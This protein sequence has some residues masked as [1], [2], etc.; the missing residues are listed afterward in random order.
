MRFWDPW[1]DRPE[2]QLGN[3]LSAICDDMNDYETL[4]RKYGEGVQTSLTA[5]G[6][7]LPDCYG[8]HARKLQA[9]ERMGRRVDFTREDMALDER[10]WQ[11]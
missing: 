11:D 3:I 9:W 4:C 6:T 5:Q 2:E 8:P 10:E 1:V 7:Q